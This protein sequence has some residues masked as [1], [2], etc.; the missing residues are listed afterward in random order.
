MVFEKCNKEVADHTTNLLL[1]SLPKVLHGFAR[2][3]VSSL[4]DDRLRDAMGYTVPPSWLV[5]FKDAL[6]RIRAFVTRY[7]LLPRR[8]PLVNIPIANDEEGRVFSIQHLLNEGIPAVCP[9]SGARASDGK[10][11]PVGGHLHAPTPANKEEGGFKPAAWR[12]E[13]KWYENE[14]VYSRPYSKGSVRWYAEEVKIVLG[15]LKREER[16]G[17]KKWLPVT[18]PPPEE[19]KGKEDKGKGDVVEG[20]GGFRLEEMGPK[21]LEVKGRKE[22]LADAERLFGGKIEGKWAFEP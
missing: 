3:M 10:T 2:N 8:K 20:L 4:M 11:C 18:L 12:M 13:L 7:L 22:V 19:V 14:P 21:G 16:R 15:L 17:A 9:A 1:Y 6:L 5:G